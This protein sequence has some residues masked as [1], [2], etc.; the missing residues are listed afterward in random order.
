M[1][2]PLKPFLLTLFFITLLAPEASAKF[3]GII[4]MNLTLPNGTSE[5]TY[6]FGERAQRMDMHTELEKIPEPLKTTVITS[7]SRPDEAIV[8]NYKSRT[9]A[10]LNLRTAAENA[11]LIDFDDD[12]RIKTMGEENVKG[13]PCRRVKLSSSTDTIEM[14]LTRDIGDFDTFRLLQSQN[15][16][17]SNTM[18]ARK[19]S[20]GGLDGFPA[21]IIQTNESGRTVMEISSVRKTAPQR[22]AFSVPKGYREVVDGRQPLDSRQK[23]HLK[24][25]MEKMK[26]FDQ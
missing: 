9:W 7:A 2:Q 23:E 22:S 19:L 25:L 16:R 12:Y 5:I 26:N 6:F 1:L 3:K 24:D 10:R 20:A 18:L 8:V 13:Y 4:D 11:T 21:R 17:L 14:W 15:P